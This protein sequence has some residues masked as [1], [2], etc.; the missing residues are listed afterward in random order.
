[1]NDAHRPPQ[2]PGPSG[3]QHQDRSRSV[4]PRGPA[5]PPVPPGHL[6]PMASPPGLG[7]QPRHGTTG[8]GAWWAGL[9][10][11]FLFPFLSSIAAGVAQWIIGRGQAKRGPLAAANGRRAANWGMTYLISTI[12]LVGGHFLLLWVLTRDGSTVDFFPLGI[13]LS[14]WGL[15][16]LAHLVVS[17]W[18]GIAAGAGRV[19]WANGLPLL[20]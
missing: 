4:P 19:F 20:K 10:V 13:L 12:V 16:T 3:W 11:L 5:V 18:G 8:A 14:L 2:T 9:T 6:P 7:G 1:M 15:H 17:I